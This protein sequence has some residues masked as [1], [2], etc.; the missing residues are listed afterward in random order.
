MELQHHFEQVRRLIR[1][2]QT[3]A[4][5]AAYAEQLSVYWQVGA[6]VYHRLEASVWGDKVVNQLAAWLKEKDPSLKGFDK[7]ALYR[8]KEFYSVWHGLDWNALRKDGSVIVESVSPQSE[9]TDNQLDTIVATV[10]PQFKE[11]N[12]ILS[13][14]TWS[15]H[16]EILGRASS[17]HITRTSTANRCWPL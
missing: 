6:Y 3:R 4:L 8:M 5:Q 16:I 13:L 1:Q 15:H 7:R 11:M 10:S 14:L 9:H 17:I 12:N 2:G